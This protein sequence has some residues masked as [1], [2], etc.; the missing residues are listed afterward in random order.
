M[1]FHPIPNVHLLMLETIT[2]KGTDRASL[3]SK[4]QGDRIGHME[5]PTAG[6]KANT[7]FSLRSGKTNAD[8]ASEDRPFFDASSVLGW[9]CASS[10]LNLVAL[11]NRN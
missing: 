6:W 4:T 9:V 8:N 7:P 3:L 1:D 2:E 10:L 5:L 11:L